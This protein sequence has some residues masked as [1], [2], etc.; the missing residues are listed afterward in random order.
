MIFLFVKFVYQDF[1]DNLASEFGWGDLVDEEPGGEEEPN[2]EEN[3]G[4]VWVDGRVNRWHVAVHGLNVDLSKQTFK[5]LMKCNYMK[6][7][8]SK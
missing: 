8:K 3:E 2:A 7:I 5:T 4:Q 6:Y 1:F